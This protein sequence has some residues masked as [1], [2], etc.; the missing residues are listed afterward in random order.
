[1]NHLLKSAAALSIALLGITNQSFAQADCGI[2]PGTVSILSDDFDAMHSVATRARQCA[3][4]TV[5]ITTNQTAE[6]KSIQVPALGANPASYSVAIVP[7][8]SLPPLLKNDL[9]RPLDDLI[10]KFQPALQDRQLIRIDGKV[11]AIAFMVNTQHLWYR[12]DLLEQAG[13]TPPSSYEEVLEVARTLRDK[14]IMQYPL[15]LNLKPG[16]D[17]GTE[18][19]NLYNGYGGELFAKDSAEPAISGETGIQTLEMLKKLSEYMSPDF[20][21]FNTNE[22]A[23]RWAAGE[24][25]LYNGWSSRPGSIIDPQGNSLPEVAAHS[26]FAAAPTVNGGTVPASYLWWVGFTIARN[27]TDEDAEASFQAMMH[28]ISPELLDDY[29]SQAVWLIAGYQ[30]GPAAEGAF[31]TVEAGAK[32]FPMLPYMGLMHTAL[33]ENLM[34]FLQGKESAEQA[35]AD[36]S[37]AYRAAALEAGYIQ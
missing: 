20:A 36:T 11:M 25:A 27:I 15:A 6:H 37:R 16:W 23:R 22:V 29:A 9:I 2:D 24:I 32:A 14:G 30:P 13:V 19:L 31:K 12:Q 21:T 35:L 4:D 7:N 1:M 5:Q 8:N 17:L 26:V 18:F 28:A 33:S 34:E 3:S 10:S